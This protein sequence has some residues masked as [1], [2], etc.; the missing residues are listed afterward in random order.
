MTILMMLVFLYVKNG[1][2]IYNYTTI[3]SFAL[4]KWQAYLETGDEKFTQ[5]LF[6]IIDFSFKNNVEI[7]YDGIIFLYQNLACAMNQGEA[8]SLLARSYE[9]T[10]KQEY[11]DFANKIIKPYEVLIKDYGV[12]G[13]KLNVVF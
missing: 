1:Q 8:L 5:Q 9:L 4:A 10:N 3:F 11:I 6:K 13:K 2:W 7:N 12:K